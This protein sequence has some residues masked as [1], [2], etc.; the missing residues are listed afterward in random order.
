[1]SRTRSIGVTLNI[2][3]GAKIKTIEDPCFT[4]SRK[5]SFALI[6]C[7]DHF[8]FGQIMK[9]KAMQSIILCSI[10]YLQVFASTLDHR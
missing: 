7:A 8:Q 6:F 3:F 1:M 5:T 4:Y 10:V 2:I 9:V